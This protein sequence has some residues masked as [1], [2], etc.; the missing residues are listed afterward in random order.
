MIALARGSVA[1]ALSI[2]ILWLPFRQASLFVL[3]VFPS[4]ADNL[5][6]LMN[7]NMAL[8][9]SGSADQLRRYLCN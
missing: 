3:Q 1:D 8:L 2:Y 6:S 5:H 4:I 7:V 9:S